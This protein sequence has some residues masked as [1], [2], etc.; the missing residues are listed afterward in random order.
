MKIKKPRDKMMHSENYGRKCGSIFSLSLFIQ[1]STDG[2]MESKWSS[3]V[4]C[5]H[6]IRI[7]KNNDQKKFKPSFATKYSP[8]GLNCLKAEIITLF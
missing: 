1:Y 6:I 8:F 2:K 5:Q 7:I 4:R 3:F